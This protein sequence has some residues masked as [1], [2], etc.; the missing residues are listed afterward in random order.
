MSGIKYWYDRVRVFH[1]SP[2]V[3]LCGLARRLV[4]AWCGS[5]EM[6]CGPQAA[7]LMDSISTGLD[8]ST[9]FDIMQ[10]LKVTRRLLLVYF[11]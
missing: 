1:P 11:H 2:S 9:T 7:F 4:H 8:T 5:G 6:I 10:T 3:N